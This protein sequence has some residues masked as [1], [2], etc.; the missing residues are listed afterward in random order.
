MT[1][2]DSLTL[3]ILLLCKAKN[4]QINQ[5][6][7]DRISRKDLPSFLLNYFIG[8]VLVIGDSQ[9]SSPLLAHNLY[10]NNKVWIFLLLLILLVSLVRLHYCWKLI[11]LRSDISTEVSSRRRQTDWCVGV[12]GYVKIVDKIAEVNCHLTHVASV[13]KSHWKKSI[14][15]SSLEKF[16]PMLQFMTKLRFLKQDQLGE[17]AIYR[18]L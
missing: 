16:Q 17:K 10:G 9:K 3:C 7:Q 12:K 1:S 5:F 15:E 8:I 6:L 14:K 18:G 2:E 13:L 11:R 4:L